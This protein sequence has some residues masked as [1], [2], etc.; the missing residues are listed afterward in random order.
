MLSARLAER[1]TAGRPVHVGVIGAGRFG[2]MALCQLASMRG[3]RASLVAEINGERGLRA[4]AR[5]GF[6]AAEV[7]RTDPPAGSTRRSR[8]AGPC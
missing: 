3:M 5:A 7:I 8:R 2:T 4:L 6:P 1:E